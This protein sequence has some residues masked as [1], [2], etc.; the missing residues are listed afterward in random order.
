MLYTKDELHIIDYKF[1]KI[2]VDVA[3][4]A[5]GMYYA[6][7]YSPLAPNATFVT[8]HVLQPMINVMDSIEFTT[9][10]LRQFEQES[11][12]AEGAILAGSTKFSPSKY[13]TFCPAYP[14]SRVRKGAPLCPAAMSMLY[15][16]PLDEKG[17]L[18]DE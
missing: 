7:A 3:D 8:F 16:A 18:A 4:N 14:H 15:P 6:L 17:A 1:G 2:P 11:A 13:C 10:Q 9:D 12:A 5:R